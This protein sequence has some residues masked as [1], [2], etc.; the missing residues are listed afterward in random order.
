MQR[1]E[2]NLSSKE[3]ANLGSSDKKTGEIIH[4]SLSP[5]SQRHH[6]QIQSS[7]QNQP[8]QPANP[9]HQ[10][11]THFPCPMF[12]SLTFLSTHLPSF[13]FEKKKKMRFHAPNEKK[14][15][16]VHRTP[17]QNRHRQKAKQI[18]TENTPPPEEKPPRSKE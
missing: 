2:L 18:C 3:R 6:V 11:S 5:F 7:N 14:K 16:H 17:H 8:S 13:S 15:S 9:V 10:K 1:V 12:H 4:L